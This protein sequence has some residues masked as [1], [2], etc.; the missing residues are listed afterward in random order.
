MTVID[1][2]TNRIL[3][4]VP[5]G[6]GSK[7]LCYNPQYNKV[8]CACENSHEIIV[9]T[10]STDTGKSVELGQCPDAIGC[11]PVN[12]DVY[13]ST[14]FGFLVIDG[15]TDEII[16]SFGVKSGLHGIGFNQT[17]NK[18]YCGCCE[19]TFV[20]D[21]S[22]NQVVRAVPTGFH[23]WR[24]CYDSLDNKM[25]CGGRNDGTVTVLDGTSDSVLATGTPGSLIHGLAWSVTRNIVYVDVSDSNA[26]KLMDAAGDSLL[27]TSIPAGNWPCAMCYAPETYE[28]YCADYLGN[29]IAVIDG[30]ADTLMHLVPVGR[31]P[32][33]LTWNPTWHRLYVANYDAATVSIIRD[34]LLGL[35]ETRPEIRK[36]PP[37]ATV[38]G[39]TLLLHVS[40]SA[41]LVDICGRK[42][43]DLTP[44]SNCIDHLRSGV[45][46][47]RSLNPP[48]TYKVTILR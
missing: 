31:G 21:A 33:A 17:N 43:A 5:I 6:Y 40:N 2:A 24:F 36:G 9:L 30:G 19:T 4:T 7:A 14:Y 15:Q 46:F 39:S 41:A 13:C 35:E 45:Y 25:Y 28:V 16:T 38:A 44:G 48:E 42:V 27:P 23:T 29:T 11:N 34:T 22:T 20:I 47:V 8:Y 32:T 26:V 3:A 37:L 18:V 12:N 10:C 1:G